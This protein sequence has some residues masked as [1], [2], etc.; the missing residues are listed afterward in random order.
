[1]SWRMASVVAG[2]VAEHEMRS[3]CGIELRAG[4]LALS[5]PARETRVL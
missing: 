2:G 4:A 3:A 1:M 5:R